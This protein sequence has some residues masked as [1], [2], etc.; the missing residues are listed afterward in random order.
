M[1]LTAIRSVTPP[2]TEHANRGSPLR[3][4]FDPHA[5]YRLC[6]KLDLKCDSAGSVV[7]W[8]PARREFVPL[9]VDALLLLTAFGEPRTLSEA[10][11]AL[12]VECDDEV[13]E[14]MPD[15]LVQGLLLRAEDDPPPPMSV[16]VIFD[17]I[18]SVDLPVLDLAA[19][20]RFYRDG[21]GAWVANRGPDV[22]VRLGRPSSPCARS[23]RWCPPA[24]G[25]RRSTASSTPRWRVWSLTARSGRWSP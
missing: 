14:A 6:Q 9:A 22:T 8:L 19:T 7:V 5:R 18:A 1:Y 24:S 11:E 21:L 17:R 20:L 25:S 16:P 10:C 15:Y 3:V 13:L 4:D 23:P 2:L 12:G